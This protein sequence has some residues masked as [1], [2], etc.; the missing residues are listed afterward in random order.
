MYLKWSANVNALTNLLNERSPYNPE[1][2]MVRS[3][4]SSTIFL[5]HYWTSS[6]AS[7]PDPSEK[8]QFDPTNATVVTSHI[9]WPEIIHES[10]TTRDFLPKNRPNPKIPDPKSKNLTQPEKNPIRHVKQKG[11]GHD[12]WPTTR[13]EPDLTFEH[14][15][16]LFVRADSYLSIFLDSTTFS[17]MYHPVL[18]PYRPKC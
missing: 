14:V 15:Y 11:T 2:S 4:S 5:V 10:G 8:N 7:R 1:T 12:K 13:S 18:Y 9:C 3:K 17:Y 6:W 16:P